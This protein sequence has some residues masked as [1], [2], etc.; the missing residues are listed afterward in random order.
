MCKLIITKFIGLTTRVK[1]TSDAGW[2]SI[3]WDGSLDSRANHTKAARALA[4]EKAWTG[5]WT[6]ICLPDNGG[7]VFLRDPVPRARL[8]W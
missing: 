7:Y 8:R 2:L 5:S 6:R 1:A 4:T 3:G